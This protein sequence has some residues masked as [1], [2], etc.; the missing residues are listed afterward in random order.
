MNACPIGSERESAAAAIR[1]D[2]TMTS[3]TMLP[4]SINAK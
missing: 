1:V 2:M 3:R 4:E